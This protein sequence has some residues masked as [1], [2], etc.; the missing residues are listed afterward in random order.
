[1]FFNKKPITETEEFKKSVELENQKKLEIEKLTAGIKKL[2]E[3][4]KQISI[5]TGVMDSI[6]NV[7]Q[8]AIT[9]CRYIQYGCDENERIVNLATI[10]TNLEFLTDRKERS[11]VN[12]RIATY[13]DKQIAR[14]ETE[15]KKCGIK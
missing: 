10:H 9:C 12:N 6:W 4:S 15:K 1:M 3:D 11:N 5:D 14:L 2:E 8:E 13:V 7:T